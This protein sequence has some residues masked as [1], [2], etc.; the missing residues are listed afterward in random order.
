MSSTFIPEG[1][2]QQTCLHPFPLTKENVL[3]LGTSRA[4]PDRA[5]GALWPQKDNAHSWGDVRWYWV[6]VFLFEHFLLVYNCCS[7]SWRDR[8]AETTHILRVQN[9]RWV[10]TKILWISHYPYFRNEKML[11]LKGKCLSTCFQNPFCSFLLCRNIRS[12]GTGPWSS[13]YGSFY[14]D[15][16]LRSGH[17]WRWN[18]T[19]LDTLR[20]LGWGE[21]GKTRKN[22]H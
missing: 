22:T 20:V 5:I 2:A 16:G 10:K 7:Q 12:L 1:D 4:N 9:C 8:A 19:F 18:C 6:T 3:A 13:C 21:A 14:K 15:L 11:K 17:Q